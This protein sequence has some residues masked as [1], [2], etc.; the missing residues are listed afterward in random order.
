M[1]TRYSPPPPQRRRSLLSKRIRVISIVFLLSLT[2]SAI[3]TPNPARKAIATAVVTAVTPPAEVAQ[4]IFP[5]AIAPSEVE[6]RVTSEYGPRSSVETSV[7]KSSSF[8]KGI[9]F[10]CATGEPLIAVEGGTAVYL[11]DPNGW[12]NAIIIRSHGGDQFLYAHAT[13]RIAGNGKLIAAGEAIATC[14]MSGNSTGP[15]LH[16]EFWPKSGDPINP[17]PYLEDRGLPKKP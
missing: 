4:L 9:D 8:H 10:A 15:H 6:V 16:F 17:R 14:G 1:L 7:G 3:F 12:G 11:N 2:F 13:E 5:L